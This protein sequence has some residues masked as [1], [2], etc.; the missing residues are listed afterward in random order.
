MDV[1]MCLSRQLY[2]ELTANS[3]DPTPFEPVRRAGM[4]AGLSDSELVE[5]IKRRNEEGKSTYLL[6]QEYKSRLNS[7]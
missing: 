1:K 4:N 6:R 2:Q 3:V 5:T 7:E